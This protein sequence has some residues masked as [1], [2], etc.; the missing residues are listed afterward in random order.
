MTDMSRPP[1]APR[2]RGEGASWVIGV[3]LILLG[4]VF[5]LQQGGYLTLTGNWWAIFIYLAAFGTLANA[6]RVWRAHHS[7]GTAA[8]SSLTWGLVLLVVASIFMFDLEWDKWWPAILIAVGSG[9]LAGYL[10]GDR[11]SADHEG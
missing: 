11:G 4:V 9:I 8:T 6:W 1:Q 5:M 2:S 10:L 3:V 7:F